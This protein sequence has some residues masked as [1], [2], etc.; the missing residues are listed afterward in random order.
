MRGVYVLTALVALGFATWIGILVINGVR[1][2]MKKRANKK[3]LQ[4]NQQNQR[5][6]NGDQWNNPGP[7][8]YHY[9]LGGEES[10]KR[11]V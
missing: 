3:E 9:P 2:W 5:Q 11:W 4:Q 6:D 8:H 7:T 10:D 1:S